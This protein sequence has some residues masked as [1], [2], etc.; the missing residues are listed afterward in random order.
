MKRIAW[1]RGMRL[2]DEIFRASDDYMAELVRRSF[3]LASVGRF[4]L[5]PSTTPFEIS[6][7]IGNGTLNVDSL[8]CLA[9][10][11]NGQ[12]IDVQYDTRYSKC[13][14]TQ[15]P[16]PDLPGIEDYILTIDALPGQWTET[17]EGLEEPVYSFSLRPVDSAIPDNAMPI[18]RIVDEYGWR[19]DEVDFV[20]PCL[21]IASH[22]KYIDLHQ[23][24]VDVLAMIDVKSQA[25]I[26]SGARNMISI[27]LPL[28]QQLRIAADKECDLL[29]PMMLLSNVQKCVSAFTCA[30]SLDENIE[31]SN[32]KMFQGFVL[33]PYNY[34][35]AYQRIKVG[36]S[37]CFSIAEKVEKIAESTI[38]NPEPVRRHEVAHTIAMPALSNDVLVQICNTSE[39][40][41]PVL[42]ENTSATIFFTI[43]GST[44]TP[45]S[46]RAAKTR[47]GFKLKFDNGFRKE[48]NRESD[49]RITVKLL[50]VIGGESSAIATYTIALKK[51]LKFR[52]AIPI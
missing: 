46:A 6:L 20:P 15:V 43:D 34:K 51:D 27:F 16:I 24:F 44:P 21:Y 35:E 5:L 42:Y 11:K 45:N 39:S 36:L 10:T 19:M 37:L 49:K 38:V 3:V 13:F 31:L 52:N 50:A 28:I 26:K 48:N 1:K 30:C 29:T 47:D 8:N 18:A 7:N 14:D 9:V 40:I 22:S 23:R 32:S 25:A 33:A 12:L 41:I 4:G 2:T 17:T